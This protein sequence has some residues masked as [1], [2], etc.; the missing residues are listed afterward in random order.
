MYYRM[1]CSNGCEGPYPNIS[2]IHIYDKFVR[3]L[4]ILY[5]K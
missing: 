2:Y 3:F 1:N 5:C 4:A